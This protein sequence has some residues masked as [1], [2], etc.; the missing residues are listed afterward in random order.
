MS[1]A[2]MPT[3]TEIEAVIVNYLARPCA[4]QHSNRSL[5]EEVALHFRNYS[6]QTRRVARIAWAMSQKGMIAVKETPGFYGISHV[7]YSSAK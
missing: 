2:A 5:R 4:G 1:T 7:S 6:L 3:D